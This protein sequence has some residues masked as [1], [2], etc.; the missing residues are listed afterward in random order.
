MYDFKKELFIWSLMHNR[1]KLAENCWR[2]LEKDQMAGAL[3]ASLLLQSMSEN[4]ENYCDDKFAFNEQLREEATKYEERAVDILN[5]CYTED[6]K[7]A[8]KLL[9]RKLPAWGNKSLASMALSGRH[10]QFVETRCFQ[11]YTYNTWYH[12]FENK[13][14]SADTNAKLSVADVIILLFEKLQ[15]PIGKFCSYTLSYVLFLTI[16]GYF[17]ITDLR[18]G[19]G[20]VGGWEIL[21]WIW[22]LTMLLGGVRELVENEVL[23]FPGKAREYFRKNWNKYDII[24]RLVFLLAVI[25]RLALPDGQFEGAT[26]VYSVAFILSTLRI[27][28]AFCLIEYL[29]PKILMIYKM[30][31]DLA[32]FL[33]IFV[34]FMLAYGVAAQSLLYS[35]YKTIHRSVEEYRLRTFLRTVS[36]NV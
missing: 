6:N 13:Q 24:S 11:Y 4:Y 21:I 2:Y 8:P 32:F 31:S 29:G 5:K 10:M 33:L 18:P 12:G 17:I 23:G 28:P 22:S 14:A 30:T 25:L 26:I 7:S 34:V 9:K 36:T 27:L 20:T 19:P 15:T 35:E 16:F 1:V 3:T